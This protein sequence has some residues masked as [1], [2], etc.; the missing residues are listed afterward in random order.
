MTIVV[1]SNIVA[2]AFIA[3]PYSQKSLL[4]LNH[5]ITNGERL[6]APALFEF[7]ITTILRRTE[8]AGLILDNETNTL[9]QDIFS[10]PIQIIA[11]TLADH[12]AAMVWSRRIN[13]AKTYDANYL[14]LAEK[15]NA[16]FW[17]ADKRLVN[18]VR[19]LGI[20]WI[21]QIGTF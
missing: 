13:Q 7:E 15:E 3:L 8:K 16:Q 5:W 17:S 14:V 4:A 21:H 12:R 1:D 10:L 19:Q 11:P 9:L 2:A 20:E 18:G 6:I